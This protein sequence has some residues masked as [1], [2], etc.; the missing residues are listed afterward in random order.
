MQDHENI[1]QNV[2]K[3]TP[4]ERMA[5]EV[6]EMPC[7]DPQVRAT[8]M[9]EVALGYSETQAR[10]EAARC[11]Q[12]KTAPCIAGCPVSI[13][14]PAFIGKVAE[15]DYAAAAD[16]IKESNLLPAI[17][18]RVCP[19]E[20][21]CQAPCTLGKSLKSVDK[22]V[23]IGRL[24]RF[25]ADWERK[26]A[27]EPAQAG[28][29]AATDT[30]RSAAPAEAAEVAIAAPTGKRV[31]VV[32][33]GPA[34]LTVAAD[35]RRAGHE[36]VIF[37]AF[38]KP[39]GVM[40][41]GIPEFRLPKAI[42]REEAEKLERMGV[43]FELNTLVGRTRPLHSLIEQEGFDAVFLGVG[44]GLPKF[45]NIPGEILIGV[46]SANEYLTRANLMK[47]W[48]SAKAA[49]P[50]YP[51]KKVAVLG[52]G[53]VAMDAARMALRLGAE[54][55]HVLYRRTRAEMPAR[56]EEVEHA[57]E[58][59]IKF[60]FLT[61]PVE[62]YSSGDGRVAG[63]VAQSYELGEPDSS[64]RRRPVA[65]PGSETKIAFDTVIVALGNESNPLLAKTTPELKVD[66]WSHILV[67][68]EQRSSMDRVWAGGD[69]VLGAATVILAMGEG[70]RAAASINAALA[71]KA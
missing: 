17:C 19:Q 27:A 53:N 3:L 10:L 1:L 45:M 4:R 57:M 48:D 31:A 70:R 69:I 24:E 54:E 41:Y 55:V 8:N 39:G 21:Q 58:E 12:C 37:E 64:G 71:G 62:I 46:F 6:Q 36:V 20:V 29:A 44:A 14:I 49:T 5:I 43:R 67:D 47:A 59:G 51:S 34:G 50:L 23:Q 65:I 33:S 15:A 2:Q 32:G 13:N 28:G 11:L 30:G 42:V 61:N 7:Q 16:I 25:V 9:Q 40:V 38:Q 52:G 60:Q 68:G 66:K 26:Q 56:A 22:A 63:V 18:G 35:V